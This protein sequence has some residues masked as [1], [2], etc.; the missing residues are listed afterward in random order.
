VIEVCFGI[1]RDKPGTLEE[2]GAAL[3]VTRERARQLE[4]DA[5]RRLR[6]DRAVALLRD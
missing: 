6:R 3:G 5:F 1:G 4:G 2:A